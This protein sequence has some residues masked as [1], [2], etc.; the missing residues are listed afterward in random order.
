M[1]HERARLDLARLAPELLVL[2]GGERLLLHSR[3]ALRGERP[4]AGAV[5]LAAALARQRV[6]RLEQPERGLDPLAAGAHPEQAAH[7]LLDPGE[8]VLDDDPILRS[9]LV[10]VRAA[11]CVPDAGGDRLAGLDRLG[12]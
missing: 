5:G 9:G 4:Q 12:E 7:G 1:R 3:R 11:T 2:V 6:G 10:R 8:T